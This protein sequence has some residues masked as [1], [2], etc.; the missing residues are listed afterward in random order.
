MVNQHL[1][2]GQTDLSC[3]VSGWRRTCRVVSVVGDRPVVLCQWLETDLSCCVSGWRQA[4]VN[5]HSG[6]GQTYLSCCRPRAMRATCRWDNTNYVWREL[7]TAGD[8]LQPDPR[9]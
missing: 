5:Q 6:C 8:C 7:T 4:V 9:W 1:G 2:S 3:C